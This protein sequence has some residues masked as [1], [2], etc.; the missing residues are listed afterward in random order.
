MSARQIEYLFSKRVRNSLG[1]IQSPRQ[2]L[3]FEQPKIYYEASGKTLN[4]QFVKNL[5]QFTDNE[6][7]NY[8]AYLMADDNGMS[9]KVAKYNGKDHVE[10]VENYEY[11]YCSLVKATIPVRFYLNSNFSKTDS[12]SRLMAVYQTG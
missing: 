5:E 10:L 9:M 6:K 2:D 11:G 3:T 12:K 1:R 8:V 7:F 4:S